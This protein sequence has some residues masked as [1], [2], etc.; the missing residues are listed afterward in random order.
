MITKFKIFEGI[1]WWR[2]GKLGDEEQ[3]DYV[4]N[5][6][7][8]ILPTRG[9]RQF[10]ID[11]DCY[12]E[13]IYNTKIMGRFNC[14]EDFL[15]KN[16]EDWITVAFTW[17]ETKEYHNFWEKR[18]EL[19]Q[20]DCRKD[21]YLIEGIR[22]WRNGK[23]SDEEPDNTPEHKDFITDDEFRKFLIDNGSYDE[24]IEYCSDKYRKNFNLAL[25]DNKKYII[26]RCLTWSSTSSGH[27]YWADLERKWRFII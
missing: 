12:D 11:N 23:L 13:F 1:R 8:D 7:D 26:D 15:K 18:H 10:L 9:F 19:W 24:F 22:W 16:I 5:S 6:Y 27:N 17:S 3:D 21:E 14:K 4:E 20:S 2:D 25:I